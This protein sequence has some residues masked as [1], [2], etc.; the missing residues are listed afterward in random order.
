V[1]RVATGRT[2]TFCK[3]S[4]AGN[5]FL[6]VDARSEPEMTDGAAEARALC[7]R[8][9]SV[10]ADGLLLV[11]PF[12]TPDEHGAVARMALWNADGSRAAFSGNAA[13]CV[14]RFLVD[15]GLADGQVGIAS[16]IG[17]VVGTVENHD[18][19]VRLP[20]I[21][22]ATPGIRL[23]VEGRDVLGTVVQ[24]GVP[25]FV[26]FHDDPDD[27]PV[28]FLGRSI[29]NHPDLAP[30]GINVDFV[31]VDDE[32]RLYFRV[33]ERGVE[34]ETLS[35][36]TGATSAALAAATAGRVQAPVACRARG[37]TLTIRFRT[38]SPEEAAAMAAETEG[39][40]LPD[41]AASFADL[42]ISG[43]V[44]HVMSGIA[45]ADALRSG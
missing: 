26:V 42:E 36:G 8:G 24:V 3:Y 18:V 10:G 6:V 15:E 11:T 39:S 2:V 21:A 7:R 38:L 16:D 29:R 9:Q 5:D 43:E 19:T 37:G 44:R 12:E 27:L 13:R 4:G 20:G 28:R 23:R 34:N 33:Y 22:S 32:Q 40:A 1:S 45:Y 35:S 17:T 14:T 30:E 31:R 41:G 25:F